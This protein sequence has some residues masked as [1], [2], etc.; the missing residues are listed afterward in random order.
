MSDARQ[1][2]DSALP[3]RG[4][5]E[6]QNSPPSAP[7]G[8]SPRPLR[9]ID[10]SPLSFDDIFSQIQSAHWY[11]AQT[12]PL[13]HA[14]ARARL[15]PELEN[16][17]SDLQT[18]I[19]KLRVDVREKTRALEDQQSQ[20]AYRDD[21]IRNLKETV[22]QLQEKQRLA[23]LLDRVSLQAQQR[24][25]A[26]PSLR[27]AFERDEPCDSYVL[28]MDIRRSTELMLKARTP[29]LFAE[30]IVSLAQALRD[31][32]ITNYGVFD[33]FTGD[34]I[35]AFFPDFFAGPDAG[36]LALRAA[37]Q[38]HQLFTRIY[39]SHRRSFIAV[40]RDT[41]LGIGI[42][43][44]PVSIVHVG[45]DFTVVGTPVVY[46]CRMAGAAPGQTYLNQ[47]A[48]E[49]IADKYSRTTELPTELHVKNEGTMLAYSA[50]L[51]SEPFEP[52]SPA[53]LALPAAG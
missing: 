29:A 17:V 5:E 46:A 36:Y 39:D 50:T 12:F 11:L 20:S 25:F 23:H 52:A 1:P 42:D 40:L 34:G 16:Q 8:S 45:T 7:Q 51:K 6:G 33:K 22:T 48:Y 47:P 43:A 49:R 9:H 35:L 13:E 27:S 15:W 28:A 2:S 30:F 4:A 26:S 14:A 31:I 32:V 41:G 19:T 3:N 24:L 44:G 18:E 38:A 21:H 10:G 53:W 37:T